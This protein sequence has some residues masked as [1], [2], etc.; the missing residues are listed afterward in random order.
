MMSPRKHPKQRLRASALGQ[1]MTESLRSPRDHDDEREGLVL[2]DS[3]SIAALNF[4]DSVAI[5]KKSSNSQ[6]VHLHLKHGS[7]RSATTGNE[8]RVSAAG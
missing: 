2:K 8:R 4:S 3:I 7:S 5:P 1:A 6:F